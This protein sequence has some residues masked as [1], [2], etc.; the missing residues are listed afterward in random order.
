M[1][2]RSG[3]ASRGPCPDVVKIAPA[4]YDGSL[5]TSI[6]ENGSPYSN[7]HRATFCSLVNV[8]GLLPP[9]SVLGMQS[10]GGLDPCSSPQKQGASAWGIPW[11]RNICWRNL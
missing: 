5:V 2:C 4:Y 6:S 1:D 7:C 10:A 9:W 3:C 11:F 8:L